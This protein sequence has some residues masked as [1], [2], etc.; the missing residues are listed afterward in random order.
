MVWPDLGIEQEGV[1]LGTGYGEDGTLKEATAGEMLEMV[2]EARDAYG[3]HR[4]VGEFFFFFLPTVRFVHGMRGRRFGPEI[5]E[6]HRCFDQT[7]AD[8]LHALFCLLMCVIRLCRFCCS[9]LL[10]V[11]NTESLEPTETN[12]KRFLSLPKI[13]S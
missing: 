4:G 7:D 2:V 13:E 3:N 1:T 6:P 12:K 9:S 10:V 5:D 11:E 8:W